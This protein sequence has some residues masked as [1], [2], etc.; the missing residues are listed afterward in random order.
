[1]AVKYV[2]DF[3]FPVAGG[4]HGVQRYAKGGHVTK[5]PAKAKDSAKGMPARAKPNAPAKG[6][7]KMESKPKVGK[8]QGYADGGKVPGR[9]KDVLPTKRPPGMEKDLAPSKPFKGEAEG[10]AKGG[11]SRVSSKVQQA[12]KN[13]LARRAAARRAAVAEPRSVANPPVFTQVE[14]VAAP[15]S[16]LPASEG[17]FRAPPPLLKEG[18]ER[19]IDF[20][21]FRTPPPLA[22]DV[23]AMPP[24]G[25]GRNPAPP[26]VPDNFGQRPSL[27]ELRRFQYENAQPMPGDE[28]IEPMSRFGGMGPRAR[29]DVFKDGGQVQKFQT[30]GRSAVPMSAREAAMLR[31]INNLIASQGSIRGG[32]TM[33]APV[34]ANPSRITKV[35]PFTFDR[36]SPFEKAMSSAQA[37][38]YNRMLKEREKGPFVDP[39][40]RDFPVEA[41]LAQQYLGAPAGGGF[42]TVPAGT[43][44]YDDMESVRAAQSAAVVQRM[45]DEANARAMAAAQEAADRAAMMAA[46]ERAQQAAERARPTVTVE[47]EPDAYVPGAVGVNTPVS[48]PVTPPL[49]SSGSV[50]GGGDLGLYNRPVTV[51]GYSGPFSSGSRLPSMAEPTYS[52]SIE[53]DTSVS[54]V[55]RPE[56][57]EELGLAHGGRVYRY[58]KGGKVGKVMREYKEGKLHSGSKK[59]PVVKSREQAVAIAL[60]EAR[61]AGEKIPKKGEGGSVFSDENMAYESKGPKTRYTPIKGRREA[62]ERAME[63]RAL[64]KARHAEKYAPGMSLDMPD[65]PVKKAKGGAFPDLTG[66]GKITRADV[67]KGRGVFKKGGKV[68]HE[69]WEHSKRDLA[70]DRKLAKKYGMSL[71]AWEKSKMDKKHDRQQ[72]MKGLKHGGVPPHRRKPMYGGGKC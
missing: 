25:G 67:L 34:V 64:D 62:K 58:A 66:D 17:Q 71:E 36:R 6:A 5:I 39:M 3:S 4:F 40:K 65:A 1:M 42:G 54:P 9:E 37:R 19:S 2:K 49:A 68:S 30:G 43:P 28:V 13:A 21:E 45:R 18:S 7:P 32:P 35:G 27:E 46:R 11:A 57:M 72:S 10:Y 50:G 26:P 61:K 48:Q 24:M 60:S 63:R 14:P 52:V 29:A 47:A 44:G 51:P 70:E 41:G 23:P 20:S 31:A 56:S 22:V 38:I 69:E 16:S 53:E 15:L 55:Y 8:G 59:G 12:L 33:R